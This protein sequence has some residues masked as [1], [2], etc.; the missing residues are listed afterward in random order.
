MHLR[1]TDVYLET[2]EYLT[3][4][5]TKERPGCVTSCI[6]VRLHEI[7]RHEHDQNI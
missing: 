5:L 7:H 1:G 2:L 4:G 6:T 3:D